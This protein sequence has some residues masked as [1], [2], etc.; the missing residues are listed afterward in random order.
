MDAW[1]PGCLDAF[2]MGCL[3]LLC[4]R[5]HQFEGPGGGGG[6]EVCR[7]GIPC[8]PGLRR[9]VALLRWSNKGFLQSGMLGCL[10]ARMPPGVSG[11][12]GFGDA[13]LEGIEEV[14]GLKS[15]AGGSCVPFKMI[16]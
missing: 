5:E 7:P 11:L 10:D 1:M 3:A 12:E 16:E 13:G 14:R 4:R 6:L 2:Q 8:G 9:A 15:P